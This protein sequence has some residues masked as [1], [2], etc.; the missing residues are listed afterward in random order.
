VVN[1]EPSESE[2]AD[3]TGTSANTNADAT[4][5]GLVVGRDVVTA[6]DATKWQDA[7]FSRAAGQALLLPLVALALAAL[8]A[9]AYVS[10]R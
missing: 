4:V 10:G 6:T 9:E 5:A 2:L 8:L 3:A 1:G 7:V